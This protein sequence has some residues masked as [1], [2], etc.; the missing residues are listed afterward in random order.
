MIWFR[1]QEQQKGFWWSTLKKGEVF[2]VKK[3][4]R[5]KENTALNATVRLSGV[6]RIHKC[7][8]GSLGS[9]LD[10]TFWTGPAHPS[11]Q[12]P[13]V[14]VGREHYLHRLICL[15]WSSS[16]AGLE[17]GSIGRRDVE[18]SSGDHFPQSAFLLLLFPPNPSSNTGWRKKNGW[19]ISR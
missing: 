7:I 4:S 15:H 18:E 3:K 6:F 12:L 2:Q 8:I 10:G 1:I 19:H 17:N 13:R 5:K 16:T 9:L 11:R 14:H